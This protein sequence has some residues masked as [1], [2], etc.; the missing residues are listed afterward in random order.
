MSYQ[1]WATLIIVI[2]AVIILGGE[3]LIVRWYPRHEERVAQTWLK[4]LPYQNTTLG[5]QMQ[6][7]AGIYGSVKDIPGGV[8]IY[9]KHFFGAGP[10]LTVST[11]P[12]PEGA[13]RFSDQLLADIETAGSRRDI[14]D[15][16]FQRLTLNDRDA[17]IVSQPDAGSHSTTVTAQVIAPDRIVQAVCNTGPRHADVYAQACNE[18]L[19]SLKVSG[20]PSQLPKTPGALD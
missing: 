17:Y 12:N 3:Y 7:A 19:N 20:P 10:V 1:K 4:Q 15:Y 6:V 5:I 18:T 9:R 2:A 14:P 11:L 8:Q 13:S 16:Q